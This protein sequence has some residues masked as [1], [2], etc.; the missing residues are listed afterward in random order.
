MFSSKKITVP[1][2]EIHTLVVEKN[3]TIIYGCLQAYFIQ[4]GVVFFRTLSGSPTTTHNKG[5]MLK[6][7]P[8]GNGN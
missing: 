4:A 7:L 1:F 3:T 2:V 8:G 6:P 5:S